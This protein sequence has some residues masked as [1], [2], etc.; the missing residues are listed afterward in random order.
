MNATHHLRKVIVGAL[1]SGAIALAGLTAATAQASPQP[2]DPS[3]NTSDF[4]IPLV[5]CKQCQ[6]TLPGRPEVHPNG[7][8]KGGNNNDT[9]TGRPQVH[10]NGGNKGGTPPSEPAGRPTGGNKYNN[11]KP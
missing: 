10:P 8:N 11:D 4:N 5:E 1:M 7:G 3:I 6:Q 9:L 2:I